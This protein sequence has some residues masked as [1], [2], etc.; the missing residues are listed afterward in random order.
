MKVIRQAGLTL[1]F[2]FIIFIFVLFLHHIPVRIWDIRPF[3]PSERQLKLLEGAQH[4]FE[5][6]GRPLHVSSLLSTLS[7]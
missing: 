4:S 6:V 1:V 3:A 7:T 5:K 2:T